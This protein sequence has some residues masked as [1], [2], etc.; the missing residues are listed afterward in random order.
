MAWTL[1][2]SGLLA[3][4]VLGAASAVLIGL[5][6]GV[7][8]IGRGP[9]LASPRVEVVAPTGTEVR[10]DGDVVGKVAEV[11]P[12]ATHQVEIT[13]RGGEV[14]RTELVLNRGEHSVII[15]SQD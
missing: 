14:W 9:I 12:G 11:D 1:T 13:L 7:R 6:A 8:P 2:V 5:M 10:I 15:L 4:V 3:G